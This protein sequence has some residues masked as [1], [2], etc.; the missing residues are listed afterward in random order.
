VVVLEGGHSFEV[1]GDYS[2]P[3]NIR[4]TKTAI[5]MGVYWLKRM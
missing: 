2:D 5:E 1:N 3:V 4:N